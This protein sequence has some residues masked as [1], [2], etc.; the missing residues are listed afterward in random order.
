MERSRAG[1]D[2]LAA[3]ERGL[4]RDPATLPA[5]ERDRRNNNGATVELLK[6][7]L[8]QVAEETGV[9]AKMIATVDDLEAIAADDDADVG[10]LRGWRRLIFGEKAIELKR[11]RLALAVENGK[12]VTFD[13]QDAEPAATE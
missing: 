5:V 13:W 7:L 9:A 6:V 8:R 3:I 1:A 2:I 11:G 12:V 4:A 10:A